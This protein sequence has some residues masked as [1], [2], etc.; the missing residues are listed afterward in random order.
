M[1]N[2]T[3]NL[4]VLGAMALFVMFGNTAN[5]QQMYSSNGAFPG[6]TSVV[7]NASINPNGSSTTAWFELS[8]NSNMNFPFTTNHT[9]VGSSYG[10]TNFSDTVTGLTPNTTYFFL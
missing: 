10:D 4:I 2:Y 6:A 9:Y 3:K 8:N 1:K 7:L 5:A